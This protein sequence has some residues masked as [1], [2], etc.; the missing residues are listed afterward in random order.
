M[1]DPSS[2]NTCFLFAHLYGMRICIFLPCSVMPAICF[3]KIRCISLQAAS[4]IRLN[5]FKCLLPFSTVCDH[6]NPGQKTARSSHTVSLICYV[7]LLVYASPE[8]VGN[9]SK[10][11][12][13]HMAMLLFKLR[14]HPE[15]HFCASPP[16]AC[17]NSSF[18]VPAKNKSIRFLEM[19]TCASSGSLGQVA[20][21]GREGRSCAQN[22]HQESNPEHP[23][24]CGC[25]DESGNRNTQKILDAEHS[26]H[27]GRGVRNS[28]RQRTM[29]CAHT[30]ATQ[31]ASIGNSSSF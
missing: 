30:A 5:H 17:C 20:S 9:V 12:L 2:Q 15:Q 29:R 4:G 23:W 8:H 1:K 27:T 28:A 16:L 26:T 14:L 22:G 31:L 13:P 3:Q 25:V 10:D 21:A 6:G 18:S 19:L 24:G 11:F 7:S